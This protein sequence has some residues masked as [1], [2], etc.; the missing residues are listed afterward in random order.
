MSGKRTLG[1]E[2]PSSPGSRDF[3]AATHPPEFRGNQRFRV[4]ARLGAGGMGTV[5]KVFDRERQLEVALKGLHARSAEELLRFKNEFRSLRD[6]R[7][8]NLISLDELFEDGGHW[9]FT[10]ES[11]DG[12]DFI[13]A[14]RGAAA[15]SAPRPTTARTVPEVSRTMSRVLATESLG[16]DSGAE[17]APSSPVTLLPAD[18]GTTRDCRPRFTRLPTGTLVN[19]GSQGQRRV[20]YGTPAPELLPRYPLARPE[21]DEAKLRDAARQ[22]ARGLAA[23]HR[24]GKVHRDVKPSNILV[25]ADGRV[26]LLD[27][28]VVRD[29]DRARLADS[30]ERREVVGTVPYM[31][32]EQACGAPAGIE[33]D[34]YAFGVVLFQALTGRLPFGGATNEEILARKRLFDAPSPEAFVA[35]LPTDLVELCNQLLR[36][37]PD[38]RPSEL[39]I[40]TAL[41]VSREPESATAA[42][43]ADGPAIFVG[44]TKELGELDQACDAVAAGT[45]VAVFVEGPSGIGKSALVEQ[46]TRRLEHS[47][48]R[49]LVLRSC[50]HERESVPYNAFD[51]IVDDL[52]HYLRGVTRRRL[53]EIVPRRAPELLR[54][55]PSL[56]AIDGIAELVAG[57]AER[58]SLTDSRGRAFAALRALLARIAR[59]YLLVLVIDDIQWAGPDSLAL[60]ADLMAPGSAPPILLVATV[61]H[62]DGPE[63]CD[64]AKM[65]LGE[66]RRIRMT[67]LPPHEARLL[68]E[69]LAVHHWRV[70]LADPSAVALQSGG[71]P[72]FVEELVRFSARSGRPASGPIALE[73]AIRDRILRLEPAAQSV[74]SLVCAAGRP[75]EQGIIARAAGVSSARF[76]ELVNVLCAG[77]LVRITGVRHRDLIAPYHG[78]IGRAVYAALS[79]ERTVD[80]HRRLGTTLRGAGASPEVLALHFSR[81]GQL[82][83]AAHYREAAARKAVAA[84][85][86]DRA[87]EHYRCALELDGH[88]AAERGRLLCALADALAHAGRPRESAERYWQAADMGDPKPRDRL[89]LRR[90][91]AEQFLKGGYL[92]RGL[93]ATRAVLA[94]IGRRFP[95]TPLRTLAGLAWNH[96]RLTR[97][98]LRWQ[99][100]PEAEIDPAT[101][102]AMDVY[103]SVGAGLSMVD[104][105][106][107]AYFITAA[108]LPA[109]RLGEEFRIGRVLAAAATAEAGLGRRASATRL[110][111]ASRRAAA[112]H[113]S[114]LA[115]F[116]SEFASA[117]IAFLLDS[118]WRG[119]VEHCRTGTQLW[120][121]A[122]GA[123]EWESDV[124]ELFAGWSLYALGELK[125]L[126]KL[127]RSQIR[128]AQ[129]SGNLFM[130]VSFRTFFGP[131]HLLNDDPATARFD[132]DDAMSKWLPRGAGFGNHEYYAL[133]HRMYAALYTDTVE[134][135]YDALAA[136]WVQMK[137]SLLPMVAVIQAE[138]RYLRGAI[139]LA[140]AAHA[141]R[142]GNA[143]ECR[144]RVRRA[145]VHIRIL[146]HLPIPLGQAF[147]HLLSAG[148]CNLG[149]DLD[150]TVAALQTALSSAASLHMQPAAAAVKRRLGGMLGGDQGVRLIR[151]ADDYFAEERFARP[152]RCTASMLAGWPHPDW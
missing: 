29:V 2:G 62:S 7:H 152:D 66:V 45:A 67:G 150:Q 94:D 126:R 31:A 83:V 97:A 54:V 13:S 142:R 72:L 53:R 74:L 22:L 5:Y 40:L 135:D 60:L 122:G 20:A 101:L 79:P 80:L 103:W 25:G 123:R 114:D 49:A 104:T 113:G 33:A 11:V 93:D 35:G 61:G 51:G 138:Y 128:R 17:P 132:V 145:K 52:S 10:M 90:R 77:K 65:A 32:P 141:R 70:S 100:R 143:S 98:T 131:L 71:H 133:K 30:V 4:V 6:L 55:F 89:E 44:R 116:Y 64:A 127:A 149:G 105:V 107:G 85:A 28:G 120:R 137:G 130:E 8:P 151:E 147:S 63:L 78:R 23:L 92:D 88:S 86:F 124:L 108:A 21:F 140:R 36:R 27:F 119:C 42:A 106:R 73:D 111:D 112:S 96:A 48:R 41:G 18:E 12:T 115:R 37:R 109:L 69:R 43:D 16:K 121:R 110:A 15:T 125:R 82:E 144:A 3:G 87:A 129:L 9:Y 57:E 19:P 59:E 146:R 134:Q 58:E 56:F 1:G 81:A 39:Q 76:A 95:E 139:E 136:Q 75:L 50:C 26:V 38:K 99:P 46:F 117:A 14:V 118:D 34:W 91:A 102:T 148:V 47:G 24:A 84:L 68:A